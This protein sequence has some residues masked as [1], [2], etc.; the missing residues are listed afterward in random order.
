MAASVSQHFTRSYSRKNPQNEGKAPKSGRYKQSDPNPA[1]QILHSGAQ[2]LGQNFGAKPKMSTKARYYRSDTDSSDWDMESSTRYCIASPTSHSERDHSPDTVIGSG[3]DYHS[4]AAVDIAAGVFR[5]PTPDGHGSMPESIDPIS[6]TL[7]AKRVKTRLESRAK[8]G[9]LREQ[10]KETV[11][12]LTKILN[13]TLDSIDSLSLKQESA[14]K[15]NRSAKLISKHPHN[16]QLNTSRN[17]VTTDDE[18]SSDEQ[19]RGVTGR[20][21]L[22]RLTRGGSQSSGPKR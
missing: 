15:T 3:V 19:A 6:D 20:A 17:D 4:D 14:T 21:R 8:A 10:L 11:D 13:T 5:S 2:R 22:S 18:S 16:N 7:T 9:G 1:E 12:S